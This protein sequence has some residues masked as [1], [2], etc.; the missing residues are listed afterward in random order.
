MTHVRELVERLRAAMPQYLRGLLSSDDIEG[1]LSGAASEI[2]SLRARLAEVEGKAA[3]SA[4]LAMH[5]EAELLL[6]IRALR[7]SKA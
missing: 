5:K 3:E 2:E 1:D 4:T 7:N 6:E